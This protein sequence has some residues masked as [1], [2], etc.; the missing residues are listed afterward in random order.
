[1][2]YQVW[3]PQGV[4]AQRAA[5]MGEY[6]DFPAACMAVGEITANS[7]EATWVP[8]Q[9]NFTAGGWNA[10]RPTRRLSV[11]DVLRARSETCRWPGACTALV[12][13]L[14]KVWNVNARKGK[15]IKK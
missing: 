12:F 6:P 1:M 7:L 10:E 3:M 8:S 11:G 13:G 15:L 14:Q 2:R 5:W 4:D 9:N